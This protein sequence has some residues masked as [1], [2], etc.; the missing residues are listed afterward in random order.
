MSTVSMGRTPMLRPPDSSGPSMTMVCPLPDSP[1]NMAPSTHL[2]CAFIWLSCKCV[3]L[4]AENSTAPRRRRHDWPLPLKLDI[5]EFGLALRL[6]G[7][8]VCHGLND[9][10]CQDDNKGCQIAD[11]ENKKPRGVSGTLQPP[12]LRPAQ[13]H[14]PC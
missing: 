10:F 14:H 13:H 9:H 4:A 2:I 5:I 8:H 12:P 6:Q 7:C 3:D 11:I 1:R